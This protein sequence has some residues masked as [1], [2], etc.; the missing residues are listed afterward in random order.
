MSEEGAEAKAAVSDGSAA[1]TP[2]GTELITEALQ[3]ALERCLDERLA[4]PYHAVII[5]ANG[6]VFV[7][8]YLPSSDGALRPELLAEYRQDDEFVAPINV[9]VT[10]ARGE[11]VQV[12]FGA[13]SEICTCEIDEDTATN[14]VGP[15]ELVL[16]QSVRRNAWWGLPSFV[17]N[18]TKTRG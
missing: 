3:L 12:R 13:S 2:E 7:A 14:L 4:L 6:S 18:F 11:S 16:E 15:G 17:R 1:G 9:F 8:R 10:D 5:G